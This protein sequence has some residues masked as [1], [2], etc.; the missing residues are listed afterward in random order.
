MVTMW[1][2]D[3]FS[4]VDRLSQME[5]LEKTWNKHIPT[6]CSYT[7]GWFVN[8]R[9]LR[10][11]LIKTLPAHLWGGTLAFNCSAWVHGGRF[12]TKPMPGYDRAFQKELKSYP[13]SKEHRLRC[14]QGEPMAFSHTKN[15]ATWLKS[16]GS[17]MEGVMKGWVPELVMLEIKRCQQLMIDTRTFPPQPEL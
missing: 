1:D 4:P 14:L 8:L 16:K 11:E 3:D 10:G 5:D 6:Y 7:Q 9:T 17:P 15:V 13:H 12:A 2:D